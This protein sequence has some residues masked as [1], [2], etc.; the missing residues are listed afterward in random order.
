MKKI[1]VTALLLIIALAFT[2]C[3]MAPDVK[4]YENR[5]Q[6]CLDFDRCM[7]Y[8]QKNQ[9]KSIC[10]D[11]AKECRA[12]GRFA[13]CKDQANLPDGMHFQECWDKLNAK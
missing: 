4:D 10:I 7:Y 9:D 6:A 3:I 11:H 1:I 12:Y 13:Y 5:P 2:A 8:N